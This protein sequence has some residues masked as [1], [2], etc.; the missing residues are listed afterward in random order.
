MFKKIFFLLSFIFYLLT[1]PVFVGA[2]ADSSNFLPP[3]D[4]YYKAKILSI[5]E[6]PAESNEFIGKTLKFEARILSGK[7][8]GKTIG[9]IYTQ[10]AE[11]SWETFKEKEKIIVSKTIIDGQIEY[12]LVEKYRLT[13]L[14]LVF[15]IFFSLAAIFGRRK[16]VLSLLGLG[17]SLL[18]LNFYVVP[19]I[20]DGGN[21]FGISF[22]G[23]LA[24]A[25]ISLF[26]AHGI[27]KRTAVA[28][29]S[30]VITLLVSA[31]LALLFVAAS[32]L[33]GA[34]SEEA[35]NLQLSLTESI[36]LRGLLLGGIIIGTLGVLDDVTTAQ[37]AAVAELKEANSSLGFGELYRRGLSIG[38]E[39]IASL[40]NTLVLAYAGASLPLFMFFTID[41]AQPLWV[42]FNSEFMAE[43]IVR[44]LVGSSALILAV[45]ISTLLAAYYFAKKS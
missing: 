29:L 22:L 28:Y 43:E 21:A 2:T 34:G 27:N 16:G 9:I 26:L 5:A 30:T 37:A 40:V 17:F 38:R 35:I 13:P 32:K 44:T 6:L 36:N 45:P 25:T 15:G 42:I 3:K 39:H 4:E 20:A 1:F 18:I 24:I 11:K 14:L 8:K 12:L 7:E 33:W 10:E 19:K 41:K 23:S 31:V